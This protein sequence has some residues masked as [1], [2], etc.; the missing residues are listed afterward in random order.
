MDEDATGMPQ[1]PERFSPDRC[2]PAVVE[3]VE[4]DGR[5]GC[6]HPAGLVV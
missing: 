2:S 6:G 4:K 3:G 1:E 5:N